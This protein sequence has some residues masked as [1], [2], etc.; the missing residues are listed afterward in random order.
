MQTT[1]NASRQITYFHTKWSS[2]FVY[3]HF[4]LKKKSNAG[5]NISGRKTIRSKGSITAPVRYAV[6]N[7]KN[8]HKLFGFV[9]NIQL[10]PKTQ[11]FCFLVVN[12][13]G[14]VFYKPTGAWRKSFSFIYSHQK[15][16]LFSNLFTNPYSLKLAA[17][18][19]LQ[20]IS[21]LEI[22][23]SKGSQYA[24]AP[25]STAKALSKNQHTH[26]ALVRLPSGVRKVFSLYNTAV[27]GTP[28]L[29]EKKQVGST[30][31]GYWRS[32]GHKSKVR[33]VAMNP[34]DHPHGGR[35]KAIRYPR[36]PWGL[37]TKF[38]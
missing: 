16:R 14:A 15:S 25:G 38:K 17:L 2:C 31:A 35:T 27:R 32:L 5:R 3:S 33:G 28:S 9:S 22:A 29:K 4:F 6:I 26:T 1:S 34:I 23:P 12:S 11:S 13:S 21:Y 19:L 18:S 10:I 30:K 37:T 20:P 36:T 24:R 8:S 7:Y